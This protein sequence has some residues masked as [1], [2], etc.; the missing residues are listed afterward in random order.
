MT[1]KQEATELVDSFI[2]RTRSAWEKSMSYKRAKDC[3]IIHVANVLNLMIQ[4]LKWD[5]KTNGNIHHY[6]EVLTEIEK[7]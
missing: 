1:P 4:K 5:E 7:L 6:Q 2:Q 3:A